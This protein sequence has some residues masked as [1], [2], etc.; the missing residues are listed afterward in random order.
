M[1]LFEVKNAKQIKSIIVSSFKVKKVEQGGWFNKKQVLTEEKTEDSKAIFVNGIITKKEERKKEFEP[2]VTIYKNYMFRE[3]L[4]QFA[5]NR[6]NT[7]LMVNDKDGNC[8]F[9]Q[10]RIH[11]KE[12][13]KPFHA[14]DIRYYTWEKEVT[15]G[16]GDKTYYTYNPDVWPY[17][18]IERNTEYYVNY[19]TAKMIM[20]EKLL[21]NCD[22]ANNKD[23]K[24]LEFALRTNPFNPTRFYN[25]NNISNLFTPTKSRFPILFDIIPKTERAGVLEQKTPI[26]EVLLFDKTSDSNYDGYGN[27]IECRCYDQMGNYTDLFTRTIEYID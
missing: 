16:I 25:L 19:L 1:D 15:V 3:G 27:W 24:D 17:N 11:H 2:I 18:V 7:S 14:I 22:D 6:C 5:N 23:L 4:F 20:I 8:I 9:Y 10:N 13:G 12:N 26:K 21:L